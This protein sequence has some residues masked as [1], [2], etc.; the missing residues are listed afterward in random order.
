MKFNISN[1]GEIEI[2]NPTVLEI[3]H[4][5]EMQRLKGVSQHGID[6]LYPWI[7]VSRFEHSLGV[8]HLLKKLGASQEEQIAGIIHDISHTAFSHVI[9]YVFETKHK[10]NFHEQKLKSIVLQSKIPKIL[11]K[12]GFEFNRIIDDKNFPLLELELP[13]LCADRIDYFLRDAHMWKIISQEQI[14][15]ILDNLCVFENQIVFKNIKIAKLAALKYKKANSTLWATPRHAAAYYVL[16]RAIKHGLQNNIIS[17]KD[18]FEQDL[19]LFNK[20]KQSNN[21]QILSNLN[22]LNENFE[23]RSVAK[24]DNYDLTIKKKL[25]YINPKIIIKNELKK[26]SELDE[27]FEKEISNYI[28]IQQKPFFIKIIRP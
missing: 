11:N 15:Q 1:Y 9:D 8:Y 7:K 21:K 16:A 25:R 2:T 23:V 18:L 6:Y 27:E 19:I 5:K 13:D 10:E 17:Y 26:L 24:I 28:D 14:N 12:Q 3:I 20:L 22:I 4:T